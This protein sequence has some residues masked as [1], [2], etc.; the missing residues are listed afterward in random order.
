MALF[1]SAFSFLS[2]NFGSLFFWLSCLCPSHTGPRKN[3]SEHPIFYR[4]V[5]AYTILILS[6]KRFLIA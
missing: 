3:Q 5:S 4:T 1:F 6:Q 2:R